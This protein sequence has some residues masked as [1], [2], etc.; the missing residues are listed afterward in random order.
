[1]TTQAPDPDADKLSTT[2]LDLLLIELVPLAYRIASDLSLQKATRN[3]KSRPPTRD[4]HD[5]HSSLQTSS[6]GTGPDALLSGS[7]GEG[8]AMRPK[9]SGAG[10]EGGASASSTAAAGTDTGTSNA[11]GGGIGLGIGL[12]SGAGGAG[13]GVGAGGARGEG[14]AAGEY[15][16]EEAREEVFYRLDGLGYRVGQGLVERYVVLDAVG[17]SSRASENTREKRALVR[18]HDTTRHDTKH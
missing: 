6:S 14:A 11:A 4:A 1:M 10:S 9:S 3:N 15:E 17:M 5:P 12:G 2:C 18:T 7:G 8:L 16:D 13:A